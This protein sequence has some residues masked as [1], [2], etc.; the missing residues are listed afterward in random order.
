[1]SRVL[2][3]SQHYASQVILNASMNTTLTSTG[4]GCYTY[5]VPQYYDYNPLSETMKL[6]ELGA[7]VVNVST[8][9]IIGTYVTLEEAERHARRLAQKENDEYYVVRPVKRFAPKP[10]DIE[11]VSL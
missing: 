6:K 10:I 11:E 8:G 5:T 3:L 4:G 1:M 7:A 2:D 9:A